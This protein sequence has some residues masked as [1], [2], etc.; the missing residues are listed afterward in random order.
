MQKF[1][2]HSAAQRRNQRK[3]GYAFVK[4]MKNLLALFVLICIGLF[5]IPADTPEDLSKVI[6]KFENYFDF[7]VEHVEV[8]GNEKISTEDILKL[9]EIKHGESLV[10]VD[11]DKISKSIHQNSW[12]SSLVISRN[13]P[14]KIRI[15]IEEEKPAAVFVDKEKLF[16]VNLAGKKIEELNSVDHITG[17]VVLKGYGANLEFSNILEEIYKHHVINKSVVEIHRK[18]DRR[19]DVILEN[20]SKIMLPERNF[21]EGIRF[22]NDFLEQNE[23][24][25]ATVIDL[26]LLPDKIFLREIK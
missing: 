25:F 17:Y 7:R 11:L 19:W 6:T 5:I 9:A 22:A 26:R 18:A 20:K 14:N 21:A 3:F 23:I 1:K 2:L 4:L 15:L 8:L 12:V 24:K 16:L 13:F 10:N